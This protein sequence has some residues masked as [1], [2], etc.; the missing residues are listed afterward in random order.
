[1]REGQETRRTFLARL[2]SGT[3]T[4]TLAVA[5]TGCDG[6]APPDLRQATRGAIEVLPRRAELFYRNVLPARVPAVRL[7][8]PVAPDWSTSKRLE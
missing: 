4:F 1:M 5:V 2:L 7:S 6:A 8:A 3:A